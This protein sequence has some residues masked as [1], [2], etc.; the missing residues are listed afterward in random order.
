MATVPVVPSRTPSTPSRLSKTCLEPLDFSALD[1]WLSLSYQG[2][3]PLRAD[4][5]VSREPRF[6]MLARAARMT[7]PGTKTTMAFRMTRAT[8][9]K[10]E[11]TQRKTSRLTKNLDKPSV[12]LCGATA[13]TRNLARSFRAH[14]GPCT[15]GH[16]C[17]PRFH[18]L[19]HLAVRR[20]VHTF[21]TPRTTIQYYLK[22]QGSRIRC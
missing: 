10:A 1:L 15:A 2:P 18:Q 6:A 12:C 5:E 20:R 14:G 13:Q 21:N 7:S 16:G 8:P 3:Q 19:A 9:A 17:V 22:Y 4:I 11:K